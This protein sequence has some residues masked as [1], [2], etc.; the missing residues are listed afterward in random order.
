M[1]TCE[2]VVLID[3]SR[4]KKPVE[5]P[6]CGHLGK[7]ADRVAQIIKWITSSSGLLGIR[8]SLLQLRVP[9]FERASR[10]SITTALTMLDA[11]K[12]ENNY[13]VRGT[14]LFQRSVQVTD[15]PNILCHSGLAHAGTRSR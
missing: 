13:A 11:Y 8:P 15:G 4:R 12:Q 7:R 10:L 2:R 3:Y 9:R 5:R 6:Y 1:F 14:K